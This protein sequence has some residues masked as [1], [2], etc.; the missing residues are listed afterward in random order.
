[1][2][3]ER[4]VPSKSEA[5]S[6]IILTAGVMTAMWK[7]NAGGSSWAISL[8]LMGTISNAGMMSLSGKV[9]SEKVDVLQLTF[10]T[11]PV[12]FIAILPAFV[13]REVGSPSHAFRPA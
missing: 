11:A 1:M 8:C 7:N 9:L 10:Y 3:F 2:L 13:F 4:K 6:L 12:S 5:V